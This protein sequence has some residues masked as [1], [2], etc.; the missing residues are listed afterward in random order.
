MKPA[1]LIDQSIK[2]FILARYEVNQIVS[3]NVPDVDPRDLLISFR[4]FILSLICFCRLRLYEGIID[5]GGA[6]RWFRPRQI[7]QL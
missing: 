6:I 3:I 4:K 1:V 2:F 5:R 7:N